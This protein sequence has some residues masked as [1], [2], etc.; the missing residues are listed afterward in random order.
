MKYRFY[1]YMIISI[2][3]LLSFCTKI[4]AQQF[5]VKSNML[6]DLTATLNVGA[7][8]HVADLYTTGISVNYNP[9]IYGDNKKMKQLLFMP[10]VRRYFED[11]FMGVF[12]GVHVFYGWYNWGGI[13]T[14]Y[15]YQGKV[16]G[17]GLSVGYQ[18]MLGPLWNLELHGGVGYARFNSDKFTPEKE[19]F[20]MKKSENS[21]VGPTQIGVS[22][23]YFIQ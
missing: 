5:A 14:D 18:W 3:G 7:E 23:V 22:I 6:Y 20:W 16:G 9:W 11:A 15:R 8:F 12:V 19:G 17:G 4:Q 13:A 21:Y 10:E 2:C 1:I